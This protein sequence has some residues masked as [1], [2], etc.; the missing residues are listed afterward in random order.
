MKRIFM[1]M[2]VILLISCGEDGR[3]VLLKT[4]IDQWG[5][6]LTSIE[7]KMGNVLFVTY[8]W[9]NYKGHAK[10]ILSK[11]KGKWEEVRFTSY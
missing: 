11:S 2:F 9:D 8:E 5:Q 1:I 7:E 6:P 4:Y 3:D 10:L